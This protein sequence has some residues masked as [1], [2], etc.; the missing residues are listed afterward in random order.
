MLQ[1][2][3]SAGSL[4]LIAGVILGIIALAKLIKRIK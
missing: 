2:L 3:E 4:A 1:A